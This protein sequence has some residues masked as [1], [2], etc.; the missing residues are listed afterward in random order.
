MTIN[1]IPEAFT[2]S[3]RLK[4]LSSLI[5]N[6][7]TFNELLEI[8]QASRGNLSV[9]LSKLEEWHYIKSHKFIEMKKTKSVYSITEY[10]LHQFEEYV[11]LLQNLLK[12]TKID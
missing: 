10:G 2:I 4:I 12:K 7:R 6:S 11:I 3:L 1:N 5:T 8:T 9:Q